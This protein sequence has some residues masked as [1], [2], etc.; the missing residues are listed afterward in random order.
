[1]KTDNLLMCNVIG[2]NW[3]ISAWLCII[4]FS[5]FC[6]GLVV[7]AMRSTLDRNQKIRYVVAMDMHRLN[8]NESYP[9]M[10]S[11]KWYWFP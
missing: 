4:W 2:R 3:L 6:Q 11:I 1:M 9:G 8:I 7:G 10:L 5:D